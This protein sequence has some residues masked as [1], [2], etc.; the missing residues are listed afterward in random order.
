MSGTVSRIAPSAERLDPSLEIQ[1]AEIRLLFGNASTSFAV[2]LIAATTLG[3]LVWDGGPNRYAVLWWLYMLLLTAT[4]YAAARRYM[5]VPPSRAQT[6][7]WRKFFVTGAAFT[8]TG[9]GATG[10]LLYSS[11]DLTTQVFVMFVVGGMMLGAGSILAPR[12][13]AYLAFLLPA[14]LIPAVCLLFRSDKI[15]LGMALFA[16]LFTLAT[17]LTT[18]QNHRTLHWSLRLRFENRDLLEQLRSANSAIEAANKELESRIRE[19]TA[20]LVRE[21]ERWATTLQSIGDAVI[22]TDN[23]GR[24]VFM[25]EV[26]QR[27][28]GWSAQEAYL[29]ELTEVFTTVHADTRG[30]VVDPVSKVLHNEHVEGPYQQAVLVRRDGVE[31]PIEDNAAPIRNRYGVIEGVVLVFHDISDRKRMEKSLLD[32]ERLSITGR[33][34]ARMAHEIHNPLDAVSN[35]LYL[36]NSSGNEAETKEYAQL[37]SQEVARIVQMTRQMLAFQRESVKPEPVAI[38]EIIADVLSLYER[39]LHEC[40]I[41]VSTEISFTGT[42][43]GRPGELRQVMANLVGNAIEAAPKK[44]TIRAYDSKDWTNGRTG[45]RITVAENGDGIPVEH[46]NAIFEPFFTTKGDNGTGLGLWITAGIVRKYDG[47]IRVRSSV[48]S[49]SSGTCFSLFLP[50]TG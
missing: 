11:T 26:A 44:L 16:G 4:R 17:C 35:L 22:S 23:Q 14:G 45:L 50:N 32:G 13:E 8:G 29:R 49:G 18:R 27:L 20:E 31:I 2:N 33:L 37:A 30:S 9:W 42:F 6:D 15:H 19:R 25:N 10:L 28:T 5:K 47:T 24:V 34:A 36:I 40:A 46:R 41:V 7:R 3:L 39:K 21:K 43:L 48:R 1:R 12:T 38:G